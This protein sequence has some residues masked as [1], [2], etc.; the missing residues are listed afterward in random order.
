MKSRGGL[1]DTLKYLG[2]LGRLWGL[3]IHAEHSDAIELRLHV[4]LATHLHQALTIYGVHTFSA[5]GGGAV[6]G[7]PKGLQLSISI[8]HTSHT[9][10]YG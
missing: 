8:A 6:V 5:V 10:K 1:V 7:Y 3:D 4:V 9:Q 2:I